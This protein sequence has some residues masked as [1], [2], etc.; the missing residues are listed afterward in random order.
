MQKEG[1]LTVEEGARLT[2]LKGF[3]AYS[4]G[5]KGKKKARVDGSDPP[6]RR[7]GRCSKIGHNSRTCKKEV[8]L[9]IE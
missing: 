9:E 3:G 4:D 6:Q 7:C 8:D 1:T 2:A 5:N